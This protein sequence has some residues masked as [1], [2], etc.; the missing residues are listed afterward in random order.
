MVVRLLKPCVIVMFIY[1]R[2][3]SSIITISYILVVCYCHVCIPS[4]RQQHHSYILLYILTMVVRLF[5]SCVIALFVYLRPFIHGCQIV[6]AV[7][8]CHVC[9]P[10]HRVQ[11]HNYIL[12]YILTMVVRLLKPCVIAMFVYLC[13]SR[14]FL[15]FLYT[16]VQT[17]CYC[18]VCIPSFKL[19]VIAMFVY[20]RSSRVLLPCLY[21]FVQA[22]CYC[23]VCIPSFKLCVIAMFVYLRSSVC[24]C[25]VCIPSFKPCVISMFVYLRSSRVLLPCLYTFVQAVCYFHVCIPSFKPC[26]IVMFVYLRSNPVSL[27]C[28]YTFVQIVCYC[29]VCIPSF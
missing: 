24:Y 12:L 18:H 27:P 3:D 8:Y 15:P 13:S 14:V 4:H 25:H 29:H 26:V 11:H 10:S 9:I 28:L 2:T 19:C 16:F 1:L 7:C 20:I 22:V 17:V 6:K 23:H 5:K 21:T